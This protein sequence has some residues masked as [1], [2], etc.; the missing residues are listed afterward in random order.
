MRPKL[1]YD[2]LSAPGVLIHEDNGNFLRLDYCALHPML[3]DA[4]ANYEDFL[5][6][7]L[8]DGDEVFLF[9]M[10]SVH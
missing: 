10:Y 7:T 1:I 9:R 5:S 3:R 6:N 4:I 2:P 8:K